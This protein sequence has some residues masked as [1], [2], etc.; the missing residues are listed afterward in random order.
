[1]RLD[2]DKLVSDGYAPSSPIDSPEAAQR[3]LDELWTATVARLAIGGVGFLRRSEVKKTHTLVDVGNYREQVVGATHASLEKALWPKLGAT[4][5]HDAG[6]GVL[7]KP[8][9]VLPVETPRVLE[10]TKADPA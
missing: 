4:V 3:R 5:L 10:W 7:P 6:A 1:M 2:T 8:R 9:M